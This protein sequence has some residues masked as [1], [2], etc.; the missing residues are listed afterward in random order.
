MTSKGTFKGRRTRKTVEH[1]NFT[2]AD[3]G[4]LKTPVD[5]NGRV[6]TKCEQYKVWSMFPATKK[7]VT[8][9]ASSCRA[10]KSAQK[11]ALPRKP[12][13]KTAVEK[14]RERQAELKRED[15]LKY[16]SKNLRGGMRERSL[17]HGITEVPTAKE[18]E[19][20][21]RSFDPFECYY[22]GIIMRHNDFSVDHKQPLNRGG[23]NDFSNLCICTK[24]MNTAKGALTEA[25][26]KSL[27]ALVETWEDKG[28]RLL[29]RLKMAGGLFNGKGTRK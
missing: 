7:T 12:P 6:C 13:S 4:Q 11:K 20:W 10:C 8:G 14:H 22:S 18:I 17:K 15:P 5:D 19:A 3:P 25:E 2:I 29:A 23:T 21:L 27:L 26:F 9:R 1:K 16:R 28:S 24:H